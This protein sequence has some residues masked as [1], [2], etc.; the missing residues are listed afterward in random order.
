MPGKILIDRFDEKDD[1]EYFAEEVEEEIE[2]QLNKEVGYG[3]SEMSDKLIYSQAQFY[4]GNVT[5]LPETQV[6]SHFKYNNTPMEM[7]RSP[8]LVDSGFM[9][10]DGTINR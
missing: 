4:C 2:K 9:Y 5:P 10:N 8:V 7:S 6:K 1:N 3:Y